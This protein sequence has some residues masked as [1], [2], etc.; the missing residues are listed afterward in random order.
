MTWGAFVAAIKALPEL[1]KLLNRLGDFLKDIDLQGDLKN[2][3]EAHDAYIK[4][5]TPEE[6]FAAMSR[7]SKLGKRL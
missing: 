3:E 1:L 6:R 4:A 7:I 5:K 2:I